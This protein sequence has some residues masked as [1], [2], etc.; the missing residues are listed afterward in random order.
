ML[1]ALPQG[2]TI[3][4]LVIVAY[5]IVQVIE[6]YLI[7]PIIQQ[8]MTSIPP[9]L[10][11]IVQIIMGALTGI[12]GVLTATPILAATLVLVKEAWIK[13]VLGDREVQS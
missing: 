4:I 7:T 3:V 6:S 11:I 12:L 10:L 1:I 13:D 5:T 9:A 2:M 8:R